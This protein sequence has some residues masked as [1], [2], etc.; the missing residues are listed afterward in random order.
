MMGYFQDD[1][2]NKSMTRL[3]VFLACLTALSMSIGMIVLMFYFE[4]MSTPENPKEL[5]H[6]P[7]VEIIMALL[8]YA[9]LKKVFQ[10]HAEKKF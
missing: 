2:G 10:K 7:I 6:L 1:K 9:G 5:N 4:A 8:A 3:L